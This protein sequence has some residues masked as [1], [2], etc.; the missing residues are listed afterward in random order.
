M[1]QQEKINWDKL[2]KHIEHQKDV[3]HD[4][5]LNQEELD[6]LLLS[7]KINMIL[8]E[9]NPEVRFPVQ[10]GWEDL[11]QRYEKKTVR[12][13]QLK[14]Y[15]MLAVAAV[16]LV[17]LIPAWW[18]FMRQNEND[19][20]VAVAKNQIR[21]T[22][23]NGETVGLDSSN[24]DI[25]KTEG[26]A[27]NGTSLV[28]KRETQLPEG[29]A[30]LPVNILSVP[31]GKYTRLELGD[32]TKVWLN[33]GSTLSYPV[34]FAAGKREVTLEGEA[35]F[36]VTHNASRP[37]VVHVKAMDV[38]VLGT[39]FSINTFGSGVHTA[40]EEGKVNLQAGSQSLILEPGEV[41][42]YE[43]DKGLGKSKADLRLYTAWKDL[44][45]YFNNNT[46]E[47]ITAR[48]Q[49]EYNVNFVFEQ[50]GLKDLHFTIDMPK[51]ADM[52][53]ILSNIRFSSDQVDFV[54]SGNVIRV[55]QR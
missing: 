43:A 31:N 38:Q 46:L 11:K 5:E 18:L 28:Y 42:T 52:N 14:L 36:D 10:E 49:R 26:A 24:A 41:G 9:Q 8:K 21:L 48:L 6:M 22:L 1:D 16:L 54:T 29:G 55:R 40:L 39:A 33:S 19:A 2:L 4:E 20:A 12:T 7:E 50:P 32:G 27:L 45:I 13:K 47:E 35:Y 37:F 25:L 34:P 15:R 3:D 30:D 23:A 53:K 51:H 44:D 17:L